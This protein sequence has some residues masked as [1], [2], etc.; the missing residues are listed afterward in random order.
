[1]ERQALAQSRVNSNKMAKIVQWNCRGLRANFEELEL[2]IK[3]YEPVAICLQEIQVSDTYILDNSLHILISKLPHI[4]TGH[5]PHGGA[6]ILIRKDIPY[7]VLP[8]NTALQAVACRVSTFQ[9]LTLCSL[10][11]PPSSSWR[12][13]DLLSLV[14]QLPPPVLLMGDFN[15]HN[16]LWGCVDTNAKGLEVT[17]FLL[18]S[19]LCLLNKKETT[20]IHPA[21]GSFSSIDLAI[22]DPAL[23]LDLSWN[24]HDDLCGSDHFPVILSTS[25]SVPQ[26]STP[27]WNMHKA[28]WGTFRLLCQAELRYDPH[29]ITTNS[30]EN[31]SAT[32]LSIATETIPKTLNQQHRQSVPWFNDSCK[33]AVADR[34]CSLQ[35]FTK[36]PTN[37]NLTHL[38]VFRAKARR[39]VRQNK[40]D[41][42]RAYVS[43]MSSQTP[44][45]KIWQMIRRISGKADPAAISHLKVNNSTIEQPSELAD[46]L[47]S[48]IAHNSS[49]DHYTDR[50]QRLKAREEK[51]QIRFSSKNLESYNQP[52]SMDELRAAIHKAHDSATGPDHIHYQMLKNLPDVALDTLLRV[53][54]D[55]WTTGHFPS[56]WSEAT[57]IPI[58]KPGKD[59]TNPGNYRPIALTSCLCKTFE[60]LVNCR[61][62]WFLEKNKILTEY[63]SG[64]R[65]SRSTTRS[66]CQIRKLYS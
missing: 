41:C 52:F 3:N 27:R 37:R 20:Y 24:V 9:P 35:A 10:Y 15:A 19:N 23:F 17:T 5:R 45:K 51:K 50:F 21:T 30:L 1:M 31:F 33:S 11:L 13:S 12:H 53:F 49:S 8:L 63:Q 22:C 56:A 14:S 26:P 39:T 25:A 4:P 40:R 65:K 61:L 64:F 66:T 2:L 57:I 43:K 62:V 28:D 16:S 59:P 34:K 29:D 54:N 6:G 7:S 42:W 47:A 48:T 32:L 18:Q 38:R 46:I 44:M 60:R 36:N 55:S 58:P